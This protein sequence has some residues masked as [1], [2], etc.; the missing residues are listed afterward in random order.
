M[1]QDVADLVERVAKIEHADGQRVSQETGVS[2]AF[3]QRHTGP[4]KGVDKHAPNKVR[5][6]RRPVGRPQGDEQEPRPTSPLVQNVVGKR[7]A[8]VNWQRHAVMEP[9]LA[10]DQDVAGTPVNVVE[11]ERDDLLA[12]QTEPGQQK[13]DGAIATSAAAVNVHGGD[14]FAN[15]PGREMA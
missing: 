7:F 12:A 4:F 3:R 8:D 6:P 13:H 2:R 11:P 1:A 10:A 9:S 15:L 14:Q 5:R